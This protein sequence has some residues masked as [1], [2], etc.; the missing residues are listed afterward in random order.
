MVLRAQLLADMIKLMEVTPDVDGTTVWQNTLVVWADEFSVG[1]AHSGLK[2][3]WTL[4]SGSNRFM[5]T[6]RF[7]DL[8][9]P[10]SGLF[11]GRPAN[12]VPHTKLLNFVVQAMGASGP[13]GDAQFQG[14][15]PGLPG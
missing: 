12:G 14:A 3:S 5:R 15:V 9:Q 11:L 10:T 6:G 2:Q 7:L 8:S 1:G 13:F 4:L